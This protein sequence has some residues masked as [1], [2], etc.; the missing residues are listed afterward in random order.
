ML[1]FPSIIYSMAS[2]NRL[3]QGMEKKQLE[4]KKRAALRAVDFIQNHQVVG[5][6][7]GTTIYFVLKELE[8]RV[9]NGLTIKGVPTSIATEKLAQEFG[10]PL[11]NLNEVPIVDLVVDGADEIDHSF[12]MVKGGGGALTREKLVALAAKKRVIVVDDS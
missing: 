11:V 8:Y 4:L 2:K 9:R 5:L 7:T 6:G 3:D 12:N 10:I 1:S